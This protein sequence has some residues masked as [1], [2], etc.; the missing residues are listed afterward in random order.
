MER[1]A[2]RRRPSSTMRILS[3]AENCR[4]KPLQSFGQRQLVDLVRSEVEA[5]SRK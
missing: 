4:R 5:A 1:D 2:L 3:S